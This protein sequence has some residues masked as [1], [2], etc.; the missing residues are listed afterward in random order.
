MQLFSCV[1]SRGLTDAIRTL[2]SK[3]LLRAAKKFAEY[4]PS[5]SGV[6]SQADFAQVM[7]R[8]GERTGRTWTAAR[9]RAMFEHGDLTGTGEIDLNEFVL[10]QQ[11]RER[12]GSGSG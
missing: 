7:T 11:K 10:M 5:R 9:L 4:D 3:E 6:I 8:L 2:S 1:G 12:K